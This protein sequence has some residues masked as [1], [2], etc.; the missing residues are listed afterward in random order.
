MTAKAR[1]IRKKFE[2]WSRRRRSVR[3]FEFVLNGLAVVVVVVIVIA[4]RQL[5]YRYHYIRSTVGFSVVSVCQD[6]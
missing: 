2:K 1:G 3:L 5:S 6:I 4:T